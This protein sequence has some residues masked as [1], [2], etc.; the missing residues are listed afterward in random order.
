[1]AVRPSVPSRRSG[2]AQAKLLGAS[3]EGSAERRTGGKG[4]GKGLESGLNPAHEALAETWGG[5]SN[6]PASTPHSM[7]TDDLILAITWKLER[8]CRLRNYKT[9]S[10]ATFIEVYDH[11]RVRKEMRACVA[12]GIGADAFPRVRSA[13]AVV[14]G[15]GGGFCGVLAARRE[16][17]RYFSYRGVHGSHIPQWTTSSLSGTPVHVFTL[18]CR[19]LLG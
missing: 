5:H 15:G 12:E 17:R 19:S 13:M 10:L 4:G 9:G 14:S 11:P 3:A 8:N 7:D 18:S 6:T 2:H 16:L 1:M